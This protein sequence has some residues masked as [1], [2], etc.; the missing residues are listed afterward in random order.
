MHLMWRFVCAT[1]RIHQCLD[2]IVK[3]NHHETGII[4]SNPIKSLKI[5]IV[6]NSNYIK[7]KNFLFNE[8][9]S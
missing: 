8:I 1:K 3:D 6:I 2:F 4:D 9:K 7:K 5:I